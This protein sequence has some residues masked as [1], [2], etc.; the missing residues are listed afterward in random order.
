MS[1]KAVMSDRA[2]WK[3]EIRNDGD[4]FFS[5]ESET[6]PG[7]YYKVDLDAAACNCAAFYFQ[8]RRN[9]KHLA[10]VQEHAKAESAPPSTKEQSELLAKLTDS[11]G[12]FAA[13]APKARDIGC[14]TLAKDLETI[15]K[16][17]AAA[18]DLQRRALSS[19]GRVRAAALAESELPWRG[20]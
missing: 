14:S 20:L 3:P 19:D 2:G 4:G 15:A 16:Q 5:V 6:Q 18:V 13:L 9:C 10:A 7:H 11:A 1:T 8:N 17:L 12:R